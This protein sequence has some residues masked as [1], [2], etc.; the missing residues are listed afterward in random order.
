MSQVIAS[1]VVLGGIY[2]FIALGFSITW[3]TTR[4]LSFAQG[5]LVTLGALLGLTLNQDL[6]LPLWVVV[7]VTMLAG[8]T[9][10]VIIHRLVIA[11]FAVLGERGVLG[12]VLATVAVSILLRNVYEMIWGLEPRRWQSPFGD[13]HISIG[14]INLQPQQ[15]AIL[16]AVG[17]LA[18]LSGWILTGT[19]YGKA[20]NAVAQ[21][22]DAAALSGISPQRFST[23]AYA[24]S[25]GI[26]ALAGMLLAPV[27]LASA[28][29]GFG[30]VVSAF[31]VAVL[32]GLMS[33]RGA[34]LVGLIFGAF[35]ALVSRY[36]GAEVKE[37][38]GLLL[39]IG[40]LM[41]SPNGLFGR[42]QVSKV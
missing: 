32:A 18:I 5:E 8:A 2:A 35:E 14:P 40:V 36:I 25:G 24:I 37:I 10:S 23:V 19:I 13:G 21:N 4:T 33:M 27:T 11:P 12:W 3:R 38:S 28:H 9:L 39:L 16:V 6:G 1:G 7:P 22:S 15:I 31:A 26:A 42:K 17:L 34:L 41:V 29:M 30:L 20:F